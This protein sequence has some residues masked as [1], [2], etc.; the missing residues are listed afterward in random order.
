MCDALEQ[1]EIFENNKRFVLENGTIKER[2]GKNG[3]V[4]IG[5]SLEYF[6]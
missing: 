4:K 5:G 2:T 6:Y 1:V 3:N